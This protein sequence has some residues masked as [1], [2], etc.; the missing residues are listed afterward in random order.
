MNLHF[1][2]NLISDYTS[3]SQQARVLTEGWMENNMFCPECGE[4]SIGH[5]N[6][7]R[8]VADFYCCKCRNDYELKSKN[9]KFSDTIV[10]GAYDTMIERITGNQNPLTSTARRAGWTGCNILIGQ[11]HEQGKIHIIRDG[12]AQN[13]ENIILKSQKTKLLEV[14]NIDSRGWL[15]DVLMCVN[16][17]RSDEF[18]LNDV[19][20]FEVELKMKHPENNNIK[21]K[22]RQQLQMLRDREYIEFLG[23]GRYRK[24][25]L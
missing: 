6:N 16:R 18:N 25:G 14:R 8:P 15:F 1:N 23:N 4:E 19:Y 11:V 21:A 9:G 22:I 17:I 2:E 10:N 13:K 5:Y 20:Q 12:I 7:N 24:V 3:L